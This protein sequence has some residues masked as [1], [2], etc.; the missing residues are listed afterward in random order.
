MG[1]SC[2][3]G[4]RDAALAA[5]RALP[6][7]WVV[8]LDLEL[9]VLTESGEPLERI[10]KAVS[11]MGALIDAMLVLSRLSRRELCREPV[12]LSELAHEVVEE[13]RAG[14]PGREVEIVVEDGLAATGD[15]E[16]L[17]VVLENL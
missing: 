3:E 17:R 11:R 10:R 2:D 8:V 4:S 1:T 5:L 15:R 16:L 7:S 14:D 6:V 9:Q 13:L 12:D